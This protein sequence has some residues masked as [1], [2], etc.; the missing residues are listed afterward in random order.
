MRTVQT[1]S[2]SLSFF[3]LENVTITIYYTP[4]TGKCLYMIGYFFF[5]LEVPLI[6][7]LFHKLNIVYLFETGE[8]SI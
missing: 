4:L 6:S 2:Y 8:E 7:Y 1:K 3:F 5:Y